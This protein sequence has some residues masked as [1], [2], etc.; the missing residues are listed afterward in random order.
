MFKCSFQSKF[1]VKFSINLFHRKIRGKISPKISVSSR[2]K[3]SW[4][5]TKNIANNY[6]KFFAVIFTS[7]KFLK[8]IDGA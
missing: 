4:E 2:P 5:W 1:G 3:R 7:T 6:F 8:M